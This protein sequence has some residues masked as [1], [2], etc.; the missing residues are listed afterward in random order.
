MHQSYNME[1]YHMSLNR[2]LK[3]FL[4]VIRMIQF[5]TSLVAAALLADI[6]RIVA[7]GRLGLSSRLISVE[8]ISGLATVYACSAF[9]TVHRLR[10]TQEDAR[11]IIYSVLDILVVGL[12]LGFI[13]VLCIA[14]LPANCGGLTRAN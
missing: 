1:C 13:V 5:I 11:L 3:L 7:V 2:R 9:F 14:G 8:V 12:Y 6:T 4:L 10:K